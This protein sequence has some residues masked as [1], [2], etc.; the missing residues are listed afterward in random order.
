MAPNQDAPMTS[1]ES[2]STTLVLYNP[3]DFDV[4]MTDG[5]ATEIPTGTVSVN[6]PPPWLVALHQQLAVAHNH[7]REIAVAVGKKQVHELTS[8]KEQ[9]EVLKKNYTVVTNLFE[10]GFEASQSQVARLE[11]QVQQASTRFASEVWAVIAQYGK[12]DA[13]RQKA[14]QNLRNASIEHQRALEALHEKTSRQQSVLGRIDTWATTKES[15]INDILTKFV[16]QDRLRE[17]EEQII[18][19]HQSTQKAIQEALEQSGQPGQAPDVAS[20]MRVLEQRAATKALSTVPRSSSYGPLASPSLIDDNVL[21]AAQAKRQAS[22]ARMQ[23]EATYA[24]AYG[25]AFALNY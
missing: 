15:Q 18:I 2:P 13:E 24:G 5:G 19:V 10:V 17:L 4:V 22:Q 23:H 6:D 21:Q 25:A 12:K 8:L 20:V 11:Q 1:V 16:D 14:I 3:V 7:I 9:Y